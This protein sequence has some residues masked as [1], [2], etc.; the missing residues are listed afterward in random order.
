MAA[1]IPHGPLY[2]YFE[3][4]GLLH[5][6][7][8]SSLHLENHWNENVKGEFPETIFSFFIQQTSQY[9][10]LTPRHRLLLSNLMALSVTIH[11][12]SYVKKMTLPICTNHAKRIL[13][14]KASLQHG[15][16]SPFRLTGWPST[17]KIWLPI[18]RL[19]ITKRME[20]LDDI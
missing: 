13:Q 9:W 2:K 8:A 17:W 7:E 10:P 5:T 6:S 15:V 18:K 14:R 1:Q 16:K 20:A 11:V 12:I 4:D 19:V 3:D